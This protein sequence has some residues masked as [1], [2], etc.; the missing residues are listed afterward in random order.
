M[1]LRVVTWFFVTYLDGDY[2][3]GKRNNEYFYIP[4][5]E[6]Y[7]KHFRKDWKMLDFILYQLAPKIVLNNKT[8]QSNPKRYG[9]IISDWELV[10]NNFLTEYEQ[11][12]IWRH[13]Q[14]CD[15]TPIIPSFISVPY[16]ART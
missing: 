13:G 9:E 1:K 5:D 16:P 3:F 8:I 6:T 7:K 15:P 12:Q 4:D 14:V 2:G 10:D 11:Y